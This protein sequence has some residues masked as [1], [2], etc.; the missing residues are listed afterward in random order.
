[1]ETTKSIPT[2]VIPGITLS[3]KR[4]LTPKGKET[5]ESRGGGGRERFF[6]NLIRKTIP[7]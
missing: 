7:W 6:Y 3:G 2:E 4:D 1:M 5:R